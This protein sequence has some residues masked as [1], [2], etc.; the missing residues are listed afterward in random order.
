MPTLANHITLRALECGRPEG[1]GALRIVSGRFLNPAQA[2]RDGHL[3]VGDYL[4]RRISTKDALRK[5]S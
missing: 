4:R 5:P 3:K 2:S 1:E